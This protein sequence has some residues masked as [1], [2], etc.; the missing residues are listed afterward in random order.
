MPEATY[1][2][3]C[4]WR[5]RAVVRKAVILHGGEPNDDGKTS[6]DKTR[7]RPAANAGRPNDSGWQYV[8]TSRVGPKDAP[9]TLVGAM[10]QRDPPQ[11]VTRGSDTFKIVR[12]RHRWGGANQEKP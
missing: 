12:T 8:P 10:V 11:Y 2:T 4:L 9:V 7:Q 1:E 5:A 6:P 3:W